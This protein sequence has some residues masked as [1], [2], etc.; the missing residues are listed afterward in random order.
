MKEQRITKTIRRIY[1]A[2]LIPAL[3]FLLFA[4]MICYQYPLGKVL[5]P[6]QLTN[7]NY[8]F[9]EYKNGQ[10]FFEI[11]VPS[12]YYT[13]YDEI[14]H[15]KKIGSYYYGFIDN[16]CV[17]F[18]LNND[19]TNQ[20]ATS[21]ENITMK[22]RHIKDT[23]K[24]DALTTQLA[25]DLSWTKEALSKISADFIVSEPDAF[26]LQDYLLLALLSIGT[27]YSLFSILLSIVCIIV[28]SYSSICKYLSNSHEKGKELT[29]VDLE[30][31]TKKE[32]TCSDTVITSSYLIESGF[33]H[34][35]LIPI[36]RVTLIYKY[37]KR[38]RLSGLS[39]HIV[40]HTLH[41]TACLKHKEKLE[42]DTILNCLCQKNPDII[43]GYSKENIRLAKTLSRAST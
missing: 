19:T 5:F 22:T 32:L 43:M 18:L 34:L 14:Q 11:T 25:T 3:L 42:A 36:D 31:A 27:L 35:K 4:G 39:Y 15:S 20:T 26:V 38:S 16:T 21:L 24:L 12:L 9:D 41:G 8:I 29:V 13:G 7:I 1:F 28:P 23:A 2:K 37:S 33:Y 17:F 6:K 10:E 30:F 40:L